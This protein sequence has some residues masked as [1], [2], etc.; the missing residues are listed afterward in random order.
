MRLAIESALPF[1]KLS[2]FS[3]FGPWSKKHIYLIWCVDRW[4]GLF[5]FERK[6]TDLNFFSDK[7][8]RRCVNWLT[9]RECKEYIQDLYQGCQSYCHRGGS[10]ILRKKNMQIYLYGLIWCCVKVSK[11][12]LHQQLL[13]CS[14][15][16]FAYLPY[17]LCL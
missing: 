11:F 4:A 17:K 5:W 2:I 8:N 1:I 16:V 3:E 7:I 15:L 6:I 13:Y 14:I 12:F 9:S 10:N